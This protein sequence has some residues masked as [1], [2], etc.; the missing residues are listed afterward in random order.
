MIALP[1]SERLLLRVSLNAAYCSELKFIP[2]YDSVAAQPLEFTICAAVIPDTPLI[3][4]CAKL[5][6][7]RSSLPEKLPET[8]SA[9]FISHYDINAS[10]FLKYYGKNYPV[11]SKL[12]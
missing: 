4:I 6:F 12:F 10:L 5:W 8:T 1:P 9:R 3:F 7:E 11:N 2:G